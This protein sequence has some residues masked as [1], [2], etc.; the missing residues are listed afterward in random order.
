LLIDNI[1]QKYHLQLRYESTWALANVAS[2][3]EIHCEA[4]LSRGAICLFANL[5]K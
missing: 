4:I 3:D 1:V 5:L 2:A